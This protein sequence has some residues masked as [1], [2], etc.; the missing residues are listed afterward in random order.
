MLRGSERSDRLARVRL[1]LR[2]SENLV[3]S[4][5]QRWDVRVRLPFEHVRDYRDA[6][7]LTVRVPSFQREL[8]AASFV[9]DSELAPTHRCAAHYCAEQ[10]IA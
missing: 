8:A 4:N 7:H 5:A 1:C 6:L 9:Q 2:R 10:T 3:E